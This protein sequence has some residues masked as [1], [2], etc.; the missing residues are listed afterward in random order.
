MHDTPTDN[1]TE[2]KGT[3]VAIAKRGK[4]LAML[5]PP[6]PAPPGTGGLHGLL[7]GSVQV[8]EGV[9]LT[10]PV[11]EDALLADDGILRR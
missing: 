10:A 3:S 2:F 4:V 1:T 6:R 7:R 11:N 9:D 8:T 5:V